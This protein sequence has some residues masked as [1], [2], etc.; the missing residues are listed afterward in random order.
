[1]NG[2]INAP[3]ARIFEKEIKYGSA[4]KGAGGAFESAKYFDLNADCRIKPY[5][6]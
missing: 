4:V 1:M 3:K 5:M 2:R 6:N